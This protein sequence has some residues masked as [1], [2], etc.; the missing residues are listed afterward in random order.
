ME[1]CFVWGLYIGSFDNSIAPLLSSTVLVYELQESHFVPNTLN[2]YDMTCF[3]VIKF[4]MLWL[5]LIYSGSVVNKTISI[6]IL[7]NQ[8]IGEFEILMMYAVLDRTDPNWSTSSLHHDTVKCALAWH[9]CPFDR[10]G[11]KNK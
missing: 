9:S 10:S 4:L 8:M 6:W 1:I 5:R 3:N 2:K 7:L 11:V